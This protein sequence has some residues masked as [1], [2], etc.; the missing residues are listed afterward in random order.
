MQAWGELHTG[1]PEPGIETGPLH[2]E[3][4]TDIIKIQNTCFVC[5][6]FRGGRP[7][8]ICGISI[9]LFIVLYAVCVLCIRLKKTC[10]KISSI[11][12]VIWCFDWSCQKKIPVLLR[13]KQPTWH[14]DIVM[15]E[16]NKKLR[17]TSFLWAEFFATTPIKLCKCT[18]TCDQWGHV[19]LFRVYFVFV[20]NTSFSHEI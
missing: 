9:H 1:K 19:L 5:L 15:L 17:I 14:R 4:D 20:P 6:F 7:E 18:S 8:Q 11:K 12:Q 16:Q 10:I 13:S 2:C 3:V